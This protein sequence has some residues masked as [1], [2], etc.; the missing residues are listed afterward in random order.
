VVF[1]CGY[2]ELRRL[3]LVYLWEARSSDAIPSF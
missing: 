1:L 2:G 3:V